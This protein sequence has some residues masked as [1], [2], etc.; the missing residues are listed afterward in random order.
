MRRDGGSES[1][2]EK[3]PDPDALLSR[4]AAEER[5]A[6]RG[7]LRIFLGYAA[8]V[9][10]TYAMLLAAR[11]RKAEGVDV[12]VAYAETHGRAETDALLEGLESLPRRQVEHRGARLAELDVDATLARHPVLALVDELAHTNAPGS[13]HAKRHQD[14]DELLCAGIDVYT[15]LNVQHVESLADAVARITGVAMRERVPDGVLDEAAE[16]SLIDLPP[17]E[18]RQRLAEGKVYVPERAALATERFFR[19]GNLMALRELATRWAATRADHDLQTFMQA[20]AIR[21]PWPVAERVLVC[22][23]GGPQSERL[24]RAARRLADGLGA[25]WFA[26]HVETTAVDRISR[27]NRERIWRDLSL[28][29][30]LGARTATVSGSSVGEA[31]TA[32]ARERN[33][34]KIV[35]GRPSP[36]P[37]WVFWRGQPTDELVRARV[38]VDVLVLATEEEP[39]RARARPA[40]RRR[41][42]GRGY[43]EGAVLVAAATLLGALLQS[44]LEPT[45]LVMAYLVAV[46]VAALRCGLGPAIATAALSV[47]AFDVFFVP[48][49][50][51][52]AVHDTQYLLTFLGLFLVGVVI[53]TLVSRARER[54]QAAREREAQ[55]ATLFGLSRDLATATDAGAIA[56]IVARHVGDL[57]HEQAVVLLSK[58][59]ALAPAGS[60]EPAA[61]GGAARADGAAPSLS[62]EELAVAAWVVKNGRAAGRGTETVAALDWAFFPLQAASGVLGVLGVRPRQSALALLPTETRHM[63]EAFASQAALALER[64]GY[65]AR[66]QQAKVLEE[67]DRLHHAILGSLSHDLRTPLATITGALTGLAGAGDAVTAET[68][69]ELLAS[70]REEAER[71]DRFVGN[72][73]EM[74]KLEAGALSVKAD[75]H[76]VDDLVGAALGTIGARARGREIRVRVPAGLPQVRADFVLLAQALVNVL[77]NALRYAP[78]AA[79]IEVAARVVGEQVEIAVEDRGPGIPEAEL[80]KVFEKFYR[81]RRGDA[82]SGTGLGLAICRGLVEANGGRVWAE[83]GGEGGARIVVRLPAGERPA[84]PPGAS[85]EDAS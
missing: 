46:V 55:T 30:A 39:R 63:L 53:S 45:N 44:I 16:I 21:G 18:L 5:R 80:E 48:P 36:R 47:L 50:L 17:D 67:A 24:I 56:G 15:C 27:E 77:D 51:S 34:T 11:A 25:E 10:K 85:R 28:A 73:L 52:I 58:D 37:W 26:V 66:A 31:L 9:G 72:L 69:R 19:P 43:L 54:T 57:L 38:P 35:I 6:Q 29:E 79:P 8:G 61:A 75:W 4:V 3:R 7:R 23:S 40:P 60:A 81:A 33:V 22:V 78:A 84:P 76:D 13:R 82:T 32:F 68:R 42:S 59:G 64:V 41:S 12:V 49:R 70:A 20:H 62:L 14:V 74:S 1:D 65:A 2:L 83:R 71:L